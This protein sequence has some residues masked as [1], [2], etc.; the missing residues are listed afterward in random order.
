MR[1]MGDPKHNRTKDLRRSQDRSKDGT[2]TS[3]VAGCNDEADHTWPL[4]VALADIHNKELHMVMNPTHGSA[5][6]TGTVADGKD[7]RSPVSSD[8]VR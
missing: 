2:H 5:Q 3:S 1:A 4:Q 8:A 6:V 7:L